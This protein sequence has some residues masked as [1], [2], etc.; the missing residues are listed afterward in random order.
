MQSVTIKIDLSDATPSASHTA[1]WIDSEGKCWELPTHCMVCGQ[2]VILWT[3]T[4]EAGV[5][6]VDTMDYDETDD[7]DDLVRGYSEE[8]ASGLGTLADV[9]SGEHFTT[10]GAQY[11]PP[12]YDRDGYR[13]VVTPREQ[14]DGN[15]EKSE[16]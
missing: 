9:S 3:N 7:L 13:I 14:T 8:I 1:H 16:D 15:R 12:G 11:Q 10:T 4:D 6:D 2:T 5:D